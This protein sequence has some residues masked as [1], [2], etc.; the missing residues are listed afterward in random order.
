[1][2]TYDKNGFLFWKL[3]KIHK[4]NYAVYG[5]RVIGTHYTSKK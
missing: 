3:Y 5:V 2:C 4:Y 1:M